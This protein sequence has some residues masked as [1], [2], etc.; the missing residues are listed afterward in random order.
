MSK[1]K[2]EYKWIFG[3]DVKFM[4]YRTGGS[5]GMYSF[6]IRSYQF[7]IYGVIGFIHTVSWG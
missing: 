4:G 7:G 3:N 1:F 2:R 5:Y 6:Q